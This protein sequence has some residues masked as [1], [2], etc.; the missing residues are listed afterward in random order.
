MTTI[1]ER[2]TVFPQMINIFVEKMKVSEEILALLSEHSLFDELPKLGTMIL[3]F[4]LTISSETNPNVLANRLS[5]FA[6]MDRFY[7]DPGQVYKTV[8][9]SLFSEL[10]RVQYEENP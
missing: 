1:S 5:L 2:I 7:R 9:T 8:I 6:S 10:K 3:K 4:T